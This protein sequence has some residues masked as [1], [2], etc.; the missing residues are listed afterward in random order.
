MD[1]VDSYG[2]FTSL[3]S[4]GSCVGDPLRPAISRRERARHSR[5]YIDHSKTEVTPYDGGKTTVLTGGVMLGGSVAR[6]V[7][8]QIPMAANPSWRQLSA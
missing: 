3:S 6:K 4:S 1:S 2:S 8:K 5:V 7:A